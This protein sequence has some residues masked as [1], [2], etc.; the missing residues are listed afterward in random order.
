MVVL[1][2]QNNL[3]RLIGFVD[4][5]DFEPS[6]V[7]TRHRV[8]LHDVCELKVLPRLSNL[9]G[10]VVDFLKRR[11]VQQKN[12]SG[13]DYEECEIGTTLLISN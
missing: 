3:S 4:G 7:T 1:K 9:N 8:V 11:L 12:I 5:R 2:L 13:P 6:N 10:I